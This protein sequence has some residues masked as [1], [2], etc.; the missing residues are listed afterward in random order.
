[1]KEIP[2]D[3]AIKIKS[4]TYDALMFQKRILS[5]KYNRN[6]TIDGVIQILLNEFTG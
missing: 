2:R 1:M 6:C 5:V 4:N 3:R